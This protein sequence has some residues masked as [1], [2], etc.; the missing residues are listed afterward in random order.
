[1]IIPSTRTLCI[2]WHLFNYYFIL[3]FFEFLK[4][5]LLK[6]VMISHG[7][8][9]NYHCWWRDTHRAFDVRQRT[10]H[11]QTGGEANSNVQTEIIL[12]GVHSSPSLSFISD[13]QQSLWKCKKLSQ[14]FLSCTGF[15]LQLLY[16]TFFS[17]FN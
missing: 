15:S 14:D 17:F 2:Y 7:S 16:T 4:I 11:I 13:L 5:S 8:E 6:E 9:R 12:V 1:M 10:L 3:F